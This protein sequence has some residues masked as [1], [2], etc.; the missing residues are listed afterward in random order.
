MSGFRKTYL[1]LVLFA[2]LL[3]IAPEAISKDY[4]LKILTLCCVHAVIVAGLTMLLGFAGQIS[5]GHAAF[6]G[7]AA[8]ATARVTVVH[9]LPMEAGLGI[10]ILLAVVVAVLIGIPSLRLTGHYLAMATLGFGVIV[11]LVFKGAM[12]FTGGPTGFT[13]IGRIPR[14]ELF[15]YSF[16]SE[17]SYYYLVAGVLLAVLLLCLNIINSRTGRALR[18]LHTSEN[19]AQTAGVDIARYKLFVFVLSAVFAAIAGFLYAHWHTHVSPSSFNFMVSVKFVT[20]VVLGGMTSIWG[21]VVGAFFLTIL[22]YF[23]QEFEHF[24]DVEIIIIG[25]ILIISMMFMPEGIVGA[26]DKGRRF[27][28]Q[29]LRRSKGASSEE[30]SHD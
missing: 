30:P 12:E 4:Y 6:Y 19:A 11:Y 21:A 29:L 3:A 17:I 1:P 22:P 8:Y 9:G 28:L 2:A 16:T 7:L 25:L 10:A 23:L 26:V 20:M 13:L 24:H 27:V 18:A 15:G 14:L 5:L